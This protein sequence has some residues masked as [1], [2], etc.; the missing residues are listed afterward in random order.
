MGMADEM[1]DLKRAVETL[2][3]KRKV[4]DKLWQYYDGLHPLVYSNDRLKEVFQSINAKFR[5]NWCGVVVDSVVERLEF[6]Q[7]DVANDE[8]ATNTL[9]RWWEISG[10]ELDADDV[11]LCAIVT[12]EAF[13]MV[14]PGEEGELEA[15]YNDSRLVHIFYEEDNPRRMR[16]A[17]K[18]WAAADGKAR[19]TLY[20]PDRLEYYVSTEKAEDV[21][22]ADDF[23]TYLT[24]PDDPESF[25]AK[26]PRGMDI[27]FHFRRERRAIKSELG[28]AVL[29]TQDAVNKL[30]ADMMVA[31]EFG[32]FKQRYIISQADVGVL[33]NAPNEIWDLPAGDGL[34]QP[35][36]VGE[37]AETGLSNFMD[38]M[39]RLA[40]SI[41]KQTRTPL[42]YFDLGKRADPSGETLAAMDAPLVKKCEKYIKRFQR[43]WERLARVV[44]ADIGAT[45]DS[46]VRAVYADPRTMQPKTEAETRKANVE[47]GIPLRTNLRR[48][49]WTPQEL[50]QMDVDKQAEAEAQQQ[51]MAVAL[52]NA[53][54]A[55]GQP[56]ANGANADAA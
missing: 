13:V 48:E 19:L 27:F 45:L 49:G 22:G 54:R 23:G 9:N 53:Q 35:T 31:A 16:Y 41:G 11:E 42:Y 52:L 2:K 8:A 26:N 32:A 34:S 12:G 43:E 7:F 44:A 6:K 46:P 33:K 30:F 38:Q 10:M 28:P 40:A 25:R 21:K 36:T 3:E 55:M 39:E 4:Y 18:W 17:A 14:W 20:Y 56:A 51:N 1:S 50:G 24:N 15:F 29:D 37:F 5:Q 47:A